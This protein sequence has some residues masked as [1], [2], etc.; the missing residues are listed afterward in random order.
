MS[1]QPSGES[2]ERPAESGGRPAANPPRAWRRLLRA[3]SP[4]ATRANVLA[5]VL[6]A[7]LGFA[8]IAQ[9]RLKQ[10]VGTLSLKDLEEIN[11]LLAR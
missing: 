1:E 8:I 2:G 5:M 4:R 3:G 7:A 9:V 10:A 6:A 11:V